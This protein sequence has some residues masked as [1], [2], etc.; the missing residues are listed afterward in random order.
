MKIGKFI[1]L[2]YYDNIKIGYGSVD[3]KNLKT[4]YI[5]L[6]SWIEPLAEIDY[7][8]TISK[9]RKAILRKIYSLNNNLF[10]KECI[11]DLDIKTKGIKL[12]KRSF[13]DLEITLF[14]TEYF[15]IKNKKTSMMILSII[16]NI[17][18]D[19]LND[20]IFYNFHKTKH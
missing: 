14:T 5:K 7:D 13:M 8:A 17:I 15:E 9:S 2:G 11:V 4:I 12:E 1:Q 18:D 20:K 19:H 3:C 16:K 10:K 6:S